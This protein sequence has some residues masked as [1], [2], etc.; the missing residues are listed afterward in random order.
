MEEWDCRPV[1]HCRDSSKQEAI[2]ELQQRG[3]L[4][5]RFEQMVH[6]EKEGKVG[7]R[8]T[9]QETIAVTEVR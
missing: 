9:S 3:Q 2:A 5:H 7:S 4:C 1:V 6:R 8:E